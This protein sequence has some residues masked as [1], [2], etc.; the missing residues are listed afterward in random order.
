MT[1]EQSTARLPEKTKVTHISEGFDFP[2]QNVR[3]YRGKLLIKASKAP[4]ASHLKRFRR[5]ENWRTADVGMDEQCR[6][7][8]RGE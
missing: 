6:A 8:A 4:D 3:K 2:G 1:V 5:G 7:P